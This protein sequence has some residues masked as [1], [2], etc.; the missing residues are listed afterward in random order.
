M[1]QK[2]LNE[3]QAKQYARDFVR[4]LQ[5]EHQ[6]PVKSAYL[7]GSYARRK[8]RA[9]SDIDVCVISPKFKRVD[10]LT[11]LWLRR[12]DLDVD[13]GIEPYGLHPQDFSKFNPIA[14]EIKQHGIKLPI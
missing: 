9:W 10:P 11:Y 1:A 7:F 14:A 2:K 8:T 3:R 13:R 6:L 4:Y 12:R 5:A